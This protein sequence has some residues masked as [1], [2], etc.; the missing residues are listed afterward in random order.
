M[1]T[2][3][4]KVA[5]QARLWASDSLLS[6]RKQMLARSLSELAAMLADPQY[7]CPSEHYAAEIMYCRL[8]RTVSG[9]RSPVESIC[10]GGADCPHA[11]KGRH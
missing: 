7:G 6:P 4:A 1:L 2:D 3:Y 8:C 11:G 9:D 10:I 5:Q